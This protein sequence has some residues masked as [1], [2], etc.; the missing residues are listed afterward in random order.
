MFLFGLC[1]HTCR[2]TSCNAND[3]SRILSRQST[4]NSN[5][6]IHNAASCATKSG[7][8]ARSRW[9]SRRVF[10]RIACPGGLGQGDLA[11]KQSPRQPGDC[12][13]KGARNDKCDIVELGSSG[14]MTL[15]K[16]SPII[17]LLFYGIDRQRRAEA[18]MGR[19]A[20]MVTLPLL[21]GVYTLIASQP[22]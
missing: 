10:R 2:H 20:T 8:I 4:Q 21:L 12:F 9:S 6:A 19:L 3:I 17:E 5:V 14:G 22:S 15:A 13:A 1:D 18:V 7:V 11:T 16:Q